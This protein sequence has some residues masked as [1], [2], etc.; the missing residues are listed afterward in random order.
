MMKFKE[1]QAVFDKYRL[2]KDR[3]VVRMVAA[4]ILANQINSKTSRPLWIM[5]VAPPGGGKSDITTTATE[6]RK[7]D[8]RTGENKHL[9]YEI[10]D[11]T[12]SSFA[13]GMRSSE[14]ETSLLKKM[15]PDG[16][17]F[18][19]K[20][21]TTILSKRKEDLI[22]IMGYLREVYD[23]KF[24]KQF[25]NGV[26]VEW[27]GRVGF[28]GS[29]TEVVYSKLEE[30]SVMGDRIMFYNIEQPDP[31]AVLDKIIENNRNNYDGHEDM[32]E[33]MTKYLEEKID[34]IRD[35]TS[36]F[37]NM[38]LGEV[39][40]KELKLVSIFSVQARSGV[41]WSFKR[42]YIREVPKTESPTRMF[43]QLVTLSK[44]LMM[45]NAHE[46]HGLI[47][48][49]NDK[50]LLYKIAFDSIS[51][52]RRR[53]IRFITKYSLGVTIEAISKE[54]GMHTESI[55]MTLDELCALQVARK[56]QIGVSSP[57]KYYI[58]NQFR[59]TV[60]RHEKL[61]V[62]EEELRDQDAEIAN[63]IWSSQKI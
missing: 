53:I 43:M 19:F 51:P 63:E 23:G 39:L 61:Q 9:C 50:Q 2:Y 59:D 48:T 11:L 10:S 21:F 55:R 22:E 60:A 12:K 25:G 34:F 18:A 42:D 17:M 28:L 46:G 3:G 33:V 49:E 38:E 58:Q 62:V 8:K 26:A 52:S 32:K 4:T 35:N 45:M 57:V 1:L 20:D 7:V 54:T 37:A 14:N 56:Q 15:N 36:L 24:D 31:E 47:L 16:G 41:I 40:E 27:K 6:V 44:T 5:F 30:I 29:C 13:S